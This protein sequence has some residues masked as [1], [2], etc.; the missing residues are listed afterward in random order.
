M[1]NSKI[2][3]RG[4]VS[5]AVNETGKDLIGLLVVA[6]I[7][8]FAFAPYFSSIFRHNLKNKYDTNNNLHLLEKVD[9]EMVKIDRILWITAII[10]WLLIIGSYIAYHS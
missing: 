9:E 5:D 10:S 1:N 8:G 2:D 4:S 6:L 7:V 3:I